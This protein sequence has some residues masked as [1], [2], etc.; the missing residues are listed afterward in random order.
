MAIKNIIVPCDGTWNGSGTMT[1][2]R[3]LANILVSLPTPSNNMQNVLPPNGFF[4]GVGVGRSLPE[5]FFNGAIA[6]DLDWKIKE[7]YKFIAK[8]FNGSCESRVWLFGFSRGAYTVRSVAGMIRNC[9][10]VRCNENDDQ[11]IDVVVNRAYDIYRNRNR[12][13][14]PD[15]P[16]A[17][18][19]R[20]S[21]SYPESDASVVFMGLW[22]T[23]GA[24]GLPS[25]KIGSGFEYLE[26]YDQFVSSNVNY[27]YQALAV[28]ENIS[29]FEPCRIFKRD[30]ATNVV[31]ERW[32][33]GIHIDIGGFIQKNPIS[34]STLNWMIDNINN[35]EIP[36]TNSPALGQNIPRVYVAP[37]PASMIVQFT[38]EIARKMLPVARIAFRD[39]F[40][41]A[42]DASIL[43]NNGNWSDIAQGLF[44]H[45]VNKCIYNHIHKYGYN[46]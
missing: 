46:S 30:H 45:K 18:E 4:Q 25:Y 23:V 27:T 34:D 5:Y 37:L 7:A 43:Y 29:V 10:V 16:E 32:F 35:A 24:H 8:N 15:S 22:D 38:R 14:H 36:N 40:I 11:N 20:A 9:G 28:H 44:L 41:P 21:F 19:F 13:C 31:I 3:R 39:R 33:P 2:V 42:L 6:S 12:E 17:R 26:F 1:N